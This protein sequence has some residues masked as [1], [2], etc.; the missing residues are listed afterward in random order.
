MEQGD[1][2]VPILSMLTR[3]PGQ[4]EYLIPPTNS[5]E[6]LFQSHTLP[7]FRQFRRGALPNIF[8]NVS[9][10]IQPPDLFPQNL[11]NVPVVL[12]REQ[13]N[14]LPLLRFI[15]MTGPGRPESDCTIC[16]NNFTRGDAIRKLRCGH[17]FHKDCI[18]PW[19]L[20]N[21][22]RCPICRMDQRGNIDGSPPQRDNN[23]DQENDCE[24]ESDDSDYDTTSL[25]HQL[26]S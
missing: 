20:N 10:D 4:I 16:L 26:Y 7:E 14:K 6:P 25:I 15:E 3:V 21:S 19:L 23:S 12:T 24:S 9:I 11:V 1:R 18:D 13:L 22:V 8:G 17:E 5:F 2:I